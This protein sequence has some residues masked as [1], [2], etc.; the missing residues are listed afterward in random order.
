MRYIKI[1]ACVVIPAIVIYFLDSGMGS[2]PPL[3]KLMDPVHGFMAN[4]ETKTAFESNTVDIADPSVKGTIVL[5]DRLVPHVFAEDEHSLY[6]L[7]GYITAKYRLWQMDIQ[8]R[9]A[10]GRLSELFGP[11]F[12]EYDL[13]QRRKGMIFGAEN[14]LATI[15]NNPKLE[16]CIQAYTDGVN[17]FMRINDSNGNVG[18][19]YAAYPIE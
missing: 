14:A 9:A 13:E 8:T 5:D 12:I 4:A 7:Q 6:Y 16:A 18:L 17:A 11:K 1:L 10:A 19:D 15:K 2:L 3:G